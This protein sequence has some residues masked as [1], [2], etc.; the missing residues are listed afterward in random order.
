MHIKLNDIIYVTSDKNK[1]ISLNIINTNR[2]KSSSNNNIKKI[3][4]KYLFDIISMW[5]LQTSLVTGTSTILSFSSH[6]YI[7]LLSF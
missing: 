3:V 1:N 4:Y 5:V 7:Q 2:S 6:F